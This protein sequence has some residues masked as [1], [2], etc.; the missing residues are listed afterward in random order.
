M[1]IWRLALGIVVGFAVEPWS[2]AVGRGWMY[3]MAALFVFGAGLLTALL[4][5]KG[6]Q[7]RRLYPM[8]SLSRTEEG[9]R[10]TVNEDEV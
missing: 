4:A 5:W 3:G 9:E 6:H 8:K 2:E 10:F 1:N 7:L